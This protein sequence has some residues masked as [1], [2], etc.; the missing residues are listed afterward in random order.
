MKKLLGIIG[1]GLGLILV[2]CGQ[3][4]EK[5][6]I[7]VYSSFEE[8]YVP[9]YIEAFNKEYPN[10]KVN[11]VRDSFG[12]IAAKFDAEKSNPQADVLWGTSGTMMMTNIDDLKELNYDVKN[13]ETKFYDVSS[14]EPKWVGISLAMSAISYNNIEGKNLQKP[15]GYKDLLKDEFKGKIVM[16]NPVSSGTGFYTVTSWIQEMGEKEAWNYMEELN[17]NILMYVHSGSAPTKM[18]AQGETLIG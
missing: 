6:E 3:K 9:S 11:L 15:I 16:P 13:I 7:V 5:K 17:K 18:V 8:D 12:I 1:I 10:I 4:E 14:K 2:G